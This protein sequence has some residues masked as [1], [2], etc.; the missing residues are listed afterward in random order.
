MKHLK[1]ISLTLFFA[2]GCLCAQAAP[3]V[4]ML[5][6]HLLKEG[7]I[8]FKKG[9]RERA[10]DTLS[11]AVLVDGNNDEARAYLEKLGITGG[12]Y[13]Q[14]ETPLSRVAH[15]NDEIK[16]YQQIVAQLRQQGEEQSEL[17]RQLQVEKEQLS[18][19][20]N[21]IE[22]ANEGLADQIRILQK[23]IDTDRSDIVRLQKDLEKINTKKHNAIARLHTDIYKLKE[24]LAA[25]ME[26]LRE[27]EQKLVAAQDQKKELS[28]QLNDTQ[29]TW[30]R[31]KLQY[32][33]DLQALESEFNNHQAKLTE[34]DVEKGRMIRQL[35]EA[36][37]DKKQELELLNNQVVIQQ[38]KLK[39]SD[40]QIARQD[41]RIV[42]L[43]EALLDAQRELLTLKARVDEQRQLE[44]RLLD[45]I[46]GTPA[47]DK[48]QEG[49]IKRQDSLIS[50]L[51]VQ[52]ATAQRQLDQ[53]KQDKGAKKEKNMDSLED[54]LTAIK[55]Q[56]EQCN[57]DLKERSVEYRLME[58]R[59]ADTQQRL[60]DVEEM[61]KS[62][63]EQIKQLEDQIT[64]A[65]IQF[66]ADNL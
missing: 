11:K 32:E 50:S 26:L 41:N 29:R 33:K 57:S 53:A 60:H 59:L 19:N 37:L 56:L 17:A 7:K 2:A 65:L 15:L 9:D 61:V 58:A 18:Q 48:T 62:K 45:K 3:Q 31:R 16:E 4:S 63:D 12:F 39:N 8:Y 42:E 25:N 22:S 55:G 20:L 28:R 64:G 36:I 5:S 47:A 44:G 46:K 43:E 40:S 13:G 34:S 66:D 24:K 38:G 27:K 52:L 23:E 49:F 14:Q 10:I 30:Q 21:D 35:Q 54:Q 51:K 6:M 1:T